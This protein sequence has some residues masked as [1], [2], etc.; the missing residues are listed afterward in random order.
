MNKLY[1]F[2]IALI[3]LVTVAG[4]TEGPANQATSPKSEP[5]VVF[6]L[7]QGWKFL[8]GQPHYA[9]AP[10]TYYVFQDGQS[11]P[12]PADLALQYS[13]KEASRSAE[14]MRDD[15]YEQKVARCDEY[16]P[17]KE[18]CLKL[19]S[20]EVIK[21]DDVDIYIVHH[22]GDSFLPGAKATQVF[23]KKDDF[24]NELIV[25]GDFQERLPALTSVVKTLRHQ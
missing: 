7:P 15:F 6:D 18:Q 1:L 19:L 20:K 11:A 5:K 24:I 9:Y 21:I 8:E 3:S 16:G 10:E 2:I 12:G 13:L 14:Q 22:Q 25:N 17:D 23:W 4:C